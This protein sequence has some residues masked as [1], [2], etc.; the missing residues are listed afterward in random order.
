MLTQVFRDKNYL[1]PHHF[2]IVQIT[3]K[4]PLLEVFYCNKVSVL[5]SNS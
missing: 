1:T 2:F 3:F 5:K 4:P